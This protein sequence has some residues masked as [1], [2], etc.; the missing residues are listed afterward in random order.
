MTAARS[1]SA[2]ASAASP[3]LWR[4]ARRGSTSTIFEREPALQEFGA[5]L[6][7]TPNATRMLARLGALAAAREIASAP[8][9]GALSAA[10]TTTSWRGCRFEGAE[11]RWGAPYLAVHRAD[12][13]RVLAEAA[14]ATGQIELKF[15]PWSPASP[16][17]PEAASS[18]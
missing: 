7:I 15:G 10:R 17:Q 8:S 3:R 18:A 9:A 14:A 12:L 5:G 13:H 6:Q 11:R 2:P 16:K 4:S 1:S